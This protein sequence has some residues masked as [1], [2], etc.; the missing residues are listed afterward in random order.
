[1]AEQVDRPGPTPTDAR[2]GLATSI[3]LLVLPLPLLQLSITIP[4]LAGYYNDPRFER[5]LQIILILLAAT[6]LGA[7]T[8]HLRDPPRARRVGWLA[9]LTAVAALEAWEVLRTN[10]VRASALRELVHIGEFG[11]LGLLVTRLLRSALTP[12]LGPVAALLYAASVAVLDET[13]QLFHPW[14]VGDL[15][16][17][18]VDVLSA[19]LGIGYALT[20]VRLRFTGPAGAGR[21]A[22]PMLAGLLA[23]LVLFFYAEARSGYLI[24][25]ER[26][27]TFRSRFPAEELLARAARDDVARYRQLEQRDARKT[28][29]ALEDFYLSETRVHILFRDSG[30]SSQAAHEDC[31]LEHFYRPAAEAL[32]ARRA[33]PPTTGGAPYASPAARDLNTHVPPRLLLRCAPLPLL[34]AAALAARRR[35]RRRGRESAVR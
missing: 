9:A 34:V 4:K 14:R 5:P 7:A 2:G 21:M 6:G 23:T 16:D 28:I 30:D 22:T 25:D 12:R 1:M 33:L 15:R 17:V 3:W 27:G 10:P 24:E 31:I 29:Y 11:V 20:V 8:R 13:V 18:Q 32:G 35:R 19:A 26:C